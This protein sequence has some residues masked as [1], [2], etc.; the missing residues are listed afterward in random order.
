MIGNAYVAA[1][2]SV[3]EKQWNPVFRLKN[4]LVELLEPD[5]GLLDQ[6]HS[7][8]I[9]SSRQLSEVQESPTRS[10]PHII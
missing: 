9:L 4:Q 10:R 3:E 7:N 1:T 6:L 2:A 8:G 5:F